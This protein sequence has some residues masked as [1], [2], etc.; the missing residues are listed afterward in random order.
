LAGVA[1]DAAPLATDALEPV[2]RRMAGLGARLGPDRA[3]P[4]RWRAA[5]R[6]WF[7]RFDVLLMPAIA[8]RMPAAGWTRRGLVNAYL[9]HTRAVPFTQAWNLADLPA[10]SVPAGLDRGG[11]PL[12]VQIV[13]PPGAERRLLEVALLLESLRPWPRLAPSP[14]R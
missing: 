4:A 1:E 5:M 2:T 14:T 10:A 12:S 11:L 9:R 8:N 13:G 6:T 3:A 7:G